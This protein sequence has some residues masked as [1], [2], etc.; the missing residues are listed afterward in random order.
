[1]IIAFGIEFPQMTVVVAVYFDGALDIGHAR[2]P[3]QMA[4]RGVVNIQ[5]SRDIFSG[6]L[7]V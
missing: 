5:I 1:M 6:A 2:P 7:S 4:S 3:N